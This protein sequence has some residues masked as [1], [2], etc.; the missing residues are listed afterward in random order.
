MFQERIIVKLFEK[1]S[2]FHENKC[3]KG[4]VSISLEF[5][6]S[7]KKCSFWEEDWGFWLKF[8]EIQRFF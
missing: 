8:C 5:F 6:A 2:S 3:T 7:N 1:N 4:K